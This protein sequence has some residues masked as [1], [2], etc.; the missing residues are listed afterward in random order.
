MKFID[1][2]NELSRLIALS[3]RRD[4]GLAVVTGRRRVGKTR[5]LV[6][7][8]EPCTNRAARRSERV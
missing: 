4:G 2:E 1:R 6:V 5:L 7:S 8:C 3:K